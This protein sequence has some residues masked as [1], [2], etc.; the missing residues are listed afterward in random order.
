MRI[1]NFLVPFALAGQSMNSDGLPYQ[2]SEPVAIYLVRHGE[3]YWNENTEMEDPYG[4]KVMGPLI[5]GSSNIELNEKGLLQAGQAAEMIS[6]LGLPIDAIYSSPLKRASKT[7]EII[8]S[9]I[10]LIPIQEPAFAACSWGVVEGRNRDYRLKTYAIDNDANYR[11]SN[12]EA[13]PTRERWSFQ[14]I[15]GAESLDA[16]AQ[17]MKA[18]FAQIAAGVKSGS[19]LL[20]VTHQENMRDLALDCQEK[21]VE[22]ARL[23]GDLKTIDKIE[24]LAPKNC[25]VHKFLYDKRTNS[26]S[27]CGEVQPKAAGAPV[28]RA[29]F[30]VGSGSLKVIV[31]D[32]D[33]VSNKILRIHHSEE[34]WVPFKRDLVL[35]GQPRF[36][37]QVQD[38][39]M[40]TFADM[41][42]RL[43]K[44]HPTEWIGVATSAAR[45]AE[46]ASEYFEKVNRELG[47]KV[48]VIPASEEGRLG[49]LT[50]VASS[51]LPKE[52]VVS[53]D[54]GSG[55]FQLAGEIDGK[56]NV[57]EGLFAY[58]TAH[59]KLL[60][61]LRG[62]Q[63]D[64]L[65]TEIDGK[66]MASSPNPISIEE[67][68]TLI[69][70]LQKLLPEVSDDFAAK[71]KDPNS[72][73]VSIG[74]PITI[75]GYAEY[76][77][78]KSTFTKEELWNAI[79]AHCGRT[80]GEL[81][82]F[83][84]YREAVL[85]MI[86][87]YSLMDGLGIDQLTNAPSRGSCEGL[88]IAENYWASENRVTRAIFDVGSGSLKVVV[89]DVDPVSQKI[90]QIHH[91]EEQW[92]PFYRDMQVSGQQRFSQE[93]QDNGMG[94]FAD[95][96]KRLAKFSPSEWIGVATSAGRKAQNAE[97]FFDKV[98]RELGI[99]VSVISVS[100]EGKLGFL[101]AVGSS[102]FPKENVISFDCGGGSFQ[103]AGEIEGNLEVVEGAFARANTLEILLTE[104]RGL[105][106]EKLEMEV[107]GK[108]VSASPNPVSM[109]EVEKLIPL[110]QKRLPHISEEFI[111][112]LKDPKSSIVG[113]G[114]D[115]TP[116]AY[117][118]YAIGKKTFTKEELWKAIQTHC[119][120]TDGELQGFPLAKQAVTG[121]VLL[122]AIMDGI[123]MDKLTN[124]PSLGSCEG[125]AIA[126]NYWK[127]PSRVTR[128]IF[129][130]GS[131]GL[132]VVIADVDP[133][134]QKILQIHHTEE[135]WVSFNRDMVVSGQPRF[136]QEV[137]DNGMRAFADMKKRLAKY[138]PSEWVGIATSA[139]RK[140]QN[141]AEFFD[142]VKDELGIKVSV[143]PASEEGKLGFLTAVAAS[144][145]PKENVIS[146]DCGGGSFQLAGEEKDGKLEVVEGPFAS[147]HA[148]E[149]LFTEIR[150]L[151]KEKI[152]IEVDGKKVSAT[153]NPMSVEEAEKL[154][155]LL[156]KRL[157]PLSE[158]FIKKLKDPKSSVVGIGGAI[159]PF[160]FAGHALGKKTFMKE[161]LWKAIEAHCGKPD[162][163]L[164][165]FPYSK[166][167]VLG[168]VLLYAIMDGFGIDKLTHAPSTGSCEGLAIDNAYWTSQKQN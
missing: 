147:T 49:F 160:G 10:G 86:L 154:V 56:F 112:K 101:T 74:G 16:V 114:G 139:G 43:E 65:E 44:Y 47:I 13:M 59:E 118:E 159:T 133:I 161:E 129:D 26:F 168:M 8:A 94:V 95:M 45:N 97:E 123:G 4:E 134:S 21:A 69:P 19:S 81:K 28:T 22:T 107:E 144:G 109:E 120:K 60:S 99:K 61:Q 48:S 124:A 145:L 80:D 105:P 165:G 137:Q 93:V 104:I 164:R 39:G 5:Q 3:T 162:S 77:L 151:S 9:K 130:V 136:S 24:S 54:C 34:Q 37:Q 146:F 113:I 149:L 71:I 103:I 40:Q 42:A 51:G 156:Q 166:Q 41:K 55:S 67:A 110:L 122:Y 158:E 25:T 87:L 126:E 116:F 102:G 15:E 141:A 153:P 6:G 53:L 72:E 132:K 119:G 32:V 35:S 142:K 150:G 89:A 66:K 27:Y 90:L 62:L 155:A 131:A 57:V 76:A 52:N 36:S 85:G 148:H 30:D 18:A 33:P 106:K 111:K 20:V 2:E 115:I 91:S 31:A 23:N 108:K 121:M 128:A 46:N 96:K 73:I 117:A 64:A 82:G 78:G 63:K 83:P 29:V 14:P 98:K 138:D 125:L 70:E 38:K 167:A 68:K 50:A 135:Q 157:P 11:G 140:A 100:E 7:A 143:V 17:R 75:F 92:V 84:D 1:E 152:E 12:W 79:E 88:A 58:V 163:E 127:S